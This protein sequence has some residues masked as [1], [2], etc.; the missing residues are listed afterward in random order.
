MPRSAFYAGV[1]G[2]LSLVRYAP[3]DDGTPLDG[4]K[5]VHFGK[6]PGSPLQEIPYRLLGY[7]WNYKCG[8]LMSF[9]MYF[10]GLIKTIPINMV[11]YRSSLI[12][13]RHYKLVPPMQCIKNKI[14]ILIKVFSLI[15]YTLQTVVS[16]V[17]RYT[18]GIRLDINNSLKVTERP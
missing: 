11:E 1:F 5:T 10:T 14:L 9:Y 16:L 15:G 18:L 6:G 8:K 7:R 2:K 13:H 12:L 17:Q 4:I 3:N